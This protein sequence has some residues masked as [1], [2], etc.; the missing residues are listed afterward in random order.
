MPVIHRFGPY[1]F[2]FYSHE[3]RESFEP[4]HIH[5]RSG[6]G[7]AVFWLEPIRLRKNWGYTRAE[8]ARVHRI[9]AANSDLRLSHWRRFFD[10][11]P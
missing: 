1:V 3:N 6:G 8:V 7:E 2:F 10:E 4:P 11:S 9:V 5:V